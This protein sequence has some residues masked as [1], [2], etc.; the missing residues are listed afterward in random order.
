MV[1]TDNHDLTVAFT[2]YVAEDFRLH[3]TARPVRLHPGSTYGVK[4]RSEPAG[5]Q[6]GGYWFHMRGDGTCRACIERDDESLDC[7]DGWQ[8]CPAET[9]GENWVVI[10][11]IGPALQFTVNEVLVAELDDATYRSGAVALWV[12]NAAETTNTLVAFDDLALFEP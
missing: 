6:S 3:V 10:Q 7:P 8:P 2:K 1:S 4:V 12:S 9:G 5:T 11:A